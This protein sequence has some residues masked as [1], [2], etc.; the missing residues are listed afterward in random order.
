M[1]P[2]GRQ[3]LD[4]DYLERTSGLAMGN[5]LDIDTTYTRN[6]ILKAAIMRHKLGIG[7]LESTVSVLEDQ[8][9]TKSKESND[10]LA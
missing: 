5:T 7:P 4:I 2:G 6:H 8:Q 9:T 3:A 10:Y 1:T